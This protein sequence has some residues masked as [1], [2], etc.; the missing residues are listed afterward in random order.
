VTPTERD[1]GG[2]Q[3]AASLSSK[4]VNRYRELRNFREAGSGAFDII[5]A[6]GRL[7]RRLV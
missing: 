7:L 2:D 4:P 5:A 3:S 6:T 1:G